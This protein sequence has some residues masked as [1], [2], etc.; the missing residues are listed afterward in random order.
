LYSDWDFV[1]QSA[2]VSESSA[3]SSKYI[4]ILISTSGL[5]EYLK[6]PMDPIQDYRSIFLVIHQ[7]APLGYNTFYYPVCL[8]VRTGGDRNV[9]DFINC[10]YGKKYHITFVSSNLLI[11]RLLIYCSIHCCVP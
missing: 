7:P 9:A 1:L 3:S 6:C 4:H 5:E 8:S 10:E 2:V 11:A